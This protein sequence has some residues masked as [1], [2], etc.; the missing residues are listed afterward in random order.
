L[1][2]CNPTLPHGPWG[3]CESAQTRLKSDLVIAFNYIGFLI[4]KKKRT[5]EDITNYLSEFTNK[6]A[7]IEFDV[8]ILHGK[9]TN[10]ISEDQNYE[11]NKLLSALSKK[12]QENTI[13]GNFHHE[14]YIILSKKR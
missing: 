14:K 5:F 1:D 8:K 4:E 12:F 11:L 2:V 9:N 7:L 13:Y 6:W 3:M 10:D